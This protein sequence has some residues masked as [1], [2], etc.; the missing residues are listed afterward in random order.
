MVH[1]GGIRFYQPGPIGLT[2]EARARLADGRKRSPRTLRGTGLR[3][4]EDRGEGGIPHE[5]VPG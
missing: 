3:I 5:S 4:H 2:A 1:V